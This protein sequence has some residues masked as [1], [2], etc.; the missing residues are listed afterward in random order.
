MVLCPQSLFLT[1][2]LRNK[3]EE[4]SSSFNRPYNPVG[5]HQL[6]SQAMA[7]GG[8]PPFAGQIPTPRRGTSGCL[9]MGG[10]EWHQLSHPGA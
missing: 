1:C 3:D 9:D 7:E 5:G 4:I 6:W 10:R 2:V 8:S